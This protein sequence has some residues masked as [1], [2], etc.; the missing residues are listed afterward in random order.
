MVQRTNN[1]LSAMATM[2][3]VS[4][5]A[6][7]KKID[8]SM[9]IQAILHNVSYHA[10]DKGVLGKK[11]GMSAKAAMQNVSNHAADR[12]ALGKADSISAEVAIQSAS[13]HAADQIVVEKR[14]R[15]KSLDR[16]TGAGT[17]NPEEVAAAHRRL[18]E[19]IM[20]PASTE[21]VS[22][23]ELVVPQW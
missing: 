13:N 16:A 17:E 2:H 1:G 12:G 7:G 3:S 20:V 6:V 5:H 10:V 15:E 14:W 4:N 18:L 21:P 8:S 22:I 19:E 23:R 9:P 11:G